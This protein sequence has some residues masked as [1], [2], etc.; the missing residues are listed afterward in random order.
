MKDVSS[1]HTNDLGCFFSTLQVCSNR[2]MGIRIDGAISQQQRQLGVSSML[3]CQRCDVAEVIAKCV[4]LCEKGNKLVRHTSTFKQVVM[5]SIDCTSTDH[6]SL[7]PHSAHHSVSSRINGSILQ[8]LLYATDKAGPGTIGTYCV[9]WCHLN[10]GSTP[11][12]MQ[13][14]RRKT[15]AAT[16]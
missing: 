1:F 7:Q 15:Q 10:S 12:L 11:R 14:H 3:L 4:S 6:T 9:S 16:G 13:S 8:V 5:T 2:S